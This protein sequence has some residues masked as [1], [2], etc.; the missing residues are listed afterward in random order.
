MR[1]R[2]VNC[3]VSLVFFLLASLAPVWAQTNGGGDAFAS[4]VAETADIALK[5]A[6]VALADLASGVRENSSNEAKLATYRASLEAEK[7]KIAAS[8]ETLKTRLSVIEDRLKALGSAPAEADVPED[9]I[10][11]RERQA[12]ELEKGAI[13]GL[14][15]RADDLAAEAARLS[16]EVT[17]ARQV[18]FANTLMKRTVIDSSTWTS[19]QAAFSDQWS[20]FVRTVGSWISFTW[21]YKRPQLL[22]ALFLSCLTALIFV[23]IGYRILGPFLARGREILEPSYI[24][25]L[26]VAF[27]S[28]VLPSMTMAAF[29]TSIYI[30]L[31]GF[32]ILRSDIAPVVAAALQVVVILF[33]VIKVTRAVLAPVK[34]NW[35]L[36]HVSDRGAWAL[37]LCVLFLVLINGADYLVGEIYTALGA[38]LV[39]TVANSFMASL[40]AGF[41]FLYMAFI[42]PLQKPETGDTERGRAWPSSIRLLLAAAGVF[43]FAAAALGY[44]GLARFVSTQIVLTGAVVVTMWI[45]FVTGRTVSQ[46][47]ALADTRVGLILRERFGL[48]DVGIDQAGLAA[49]LGIYF[50]V[51]AL[52]IPLILL[53]W[54]FY[55]QDIWIWVRAF[56]TNIEVGSIRISLVS[57]AAGALLFVVGLYFSRWLLRWIDGNVLARSNLDSGVRNSVKTGLNYVGAAIALLVGV[58]AAGIDLSSLALVAGALS[59]G[60]GF[61]LQNI[62]SNFVS[63]LILLVERPFKVGDWVVTGSTEGIVKH[64]S[65]RA[66][67]I[68]TFQH[69]SIIVPNSEL[70]NASLGNWT[71]RNKLGRTDVTVGVSYD[72]DPQKV[73]D[74]LLEIGESYSKALK[75]PEPS[76]EFI[77]FGDS[78]L[79]FSLRI[80]L[81]N[82]LDGFNARNDLRLLIFER[83][84]AEGIEIPFPQRDINI[85]VQELDKLRPV[86]R[87][88]APR[89]AKERKPVPENM[90]GLDGDTDPGGDDG[91]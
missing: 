66:T 73:F 19:A 79:D 27:W 89:K 41:V 62:V 4:S 55:A 81:A 59:L 31:D 48:S 91:R 38:P 1:L 22:A 58:S 11:A 46:P 45:G 71:H 74:L 61:G 44:I 85:R 15:G 54:G 12:L 34:P 16:S 47:D 52:G 5:D 84:Q 63:G 10:V 78:S 53:Q 72:A 13:N 26:S 77:G 8:L 14:V 33:F 23:G 29:A 2:F 43:L 90:G 40:L 65:V 42:S 80:H 24:S 64:I 67:E 39:L 60:I 28:T 37:S 69:Q 17:S 49:G 75:N 83:F 57:I 70:I 9:S 50:L 76:V 86:D 51:L 35:R 87:P 36:V 21:E 88:K 18:V 56:T 32:N 82:V 68:E 7:R 25:R 3:A 20:A 6:A 30:F